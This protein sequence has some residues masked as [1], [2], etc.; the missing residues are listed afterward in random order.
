MVGK[1]ATMK[2]FQLALEVII[3]QLIF[4]DIPEMI[5]TLNIVQMDQ[6][7]FL[8]RGEMAT[9]NDISWIETD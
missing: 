9:V 6:K 1:M 3:L 7:L 5:L 4:R 2:Y 8:N